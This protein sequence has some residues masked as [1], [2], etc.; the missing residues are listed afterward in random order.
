MAIK[1]F[2]EALKNPEKQLSIRI[3]PNYFNSTTKD[4]TWCANSSVYSKESDLE[5]ILEREK[6]AFGY[7]IGDK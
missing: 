7:A 4:V 1:C 5:T 3:P 2:V 6:R